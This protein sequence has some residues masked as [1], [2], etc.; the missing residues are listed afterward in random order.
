MKATWP[1]S[2]LKSRKQPNR[3]SNS[4]EPEEVI[5]VSGTICTLQ[6]GVIGN[7]WNAYT[8]KSLCCQSRFPWLMLACRVSTTPSNN[9]RL[10]YAVGLEGYRCTTLQQIVHQGYSAQQPYL[11]LICASYSAWLAP[12]LFFLPP[13]TQHG[14]STV[15]LWPTP[16][17]GKKSWWEYQEKYYKHCAFYS[18]SN[19]CW[20]NN[21][22][23]FLVN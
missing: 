6:K 4:G 21:R 11:L 14:I 15:N 17:D 20:I 16:I 10:W 22:A 5:Y 8:L 7:R 23:L 18:L 2:S 1:A 9:Q 3:C 19:I 13:Q 12:T